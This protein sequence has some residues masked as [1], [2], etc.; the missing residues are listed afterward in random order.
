MDRHRRT[1]CDEE[2][3]QVVRRVVRADVAADRPAVPHLDV[4]DLNGDLCEDRPC[5]RHLGRTDHVRV[6]R[7]GADLEAAVVGCPDPAQLVE[8]VEVDEQVGRGGAS[9]HH[10]RQRLA[11]GERT[12]AVVRGEQPQGFVERRGPRVLDVREEH[13]RDSK[14]LRPSPKGCS[15]CGP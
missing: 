9:L 7:H 15:R 11:A 1:Q 8:A 6:G 5:L 14:S 13:W 2:R 3:G 4:G 10:V 12:G